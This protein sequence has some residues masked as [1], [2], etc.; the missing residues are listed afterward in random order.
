MFSWDIDI[1]SHDAHG[2]MDA[3]TGAP[4]LPKRPVRIGDNV[5]LGRRVHITKNAS[6]P[7]NTVVGAC[8]VV[9]KEFTEEHTAIAG[10]PAKAIKQNVAWRREPFE[11]E[12]AAADE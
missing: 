8:A 11:A 2:L 10:N 5:W 6:I 1:W 9:T 4:I 7:N 12:E 3:K